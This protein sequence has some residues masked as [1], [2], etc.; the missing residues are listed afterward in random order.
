MVDEG[1]IVTCVVAGV[2]QSNQNAAGSLS[3]N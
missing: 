2:A 1:R 3:C